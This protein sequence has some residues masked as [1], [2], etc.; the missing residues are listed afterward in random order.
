LTDIFADLVHR[1]LAVWNE[2]NDEL[3]RGALASLW[4]HSTVPNGEHAT[5]PAGAG[6]RLRTTSDVIARRNT[7][8]FTWELA[9]IDGGEATA[10]GLDFM[11]LDETGRITE[12]HRFD[13]E[14]VQ[15]NHVADRYLA[16]WHEPDAA[17]RRR[18][19]ER[20]WA[21][22]GVLD[23]HRGRSSGHAAIAAVFTDK[24]EQIVNRGFVYER[25]S[26]V[27]TDRDAVKV[28]WQLVPT[29]GGAPVAV[30]L[31]VVAL[32]SLGRIRTAYEFCDPPTA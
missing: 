5:W 1:Y 26:N 22:D 10:Q 15:C 9:P 3:R 27:A 29:G 16:L 14:S 11:I 24:Y 13:A 19:I 8:R 32:D 21:P 31:D 23:W 30:G 17:A 2:P 4:A 12:A 20:M 18:G 6:F 7:V 28:D 25:T